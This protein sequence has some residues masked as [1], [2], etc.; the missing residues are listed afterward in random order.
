MTVYA[1]IT[2]PPESVMVF[3]PANNLNLVGTGSVLDVNPNRINLKR[4]V[5]S[6]HPIRFN[7]R[8]TIVRFMFFT[9]EDVQ[10]FRPIGLE[11]KTKKHG[12]IVEPIGTHGYMKCIFDGKMGPM[13]TV[14]MKLYKRVYPKWSYHE[15]LGDQD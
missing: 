13:D 10:Y 6:G 8:T 2:Y 9:P 5:L 12:H 7:A 14:L 1:P 4:I 3:D 11:T 15:I